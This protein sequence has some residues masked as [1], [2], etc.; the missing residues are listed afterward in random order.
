[1]AGPLG[2]MAGDLSKILSEVKVK[3]IVVKEEKA[4]PIPETPK[5]DTRE[6]AREVVAAVFGSVTPGT[7]ALDIGHAIHLACEEVAGS[8]KLTKDQV[9]EAVMTY[10]IEAVESAQNLLED[11]D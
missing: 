10:C 6:V 5:V 7:K 3:P 11:C 1:M 9:F 8:K 4:A 2:E